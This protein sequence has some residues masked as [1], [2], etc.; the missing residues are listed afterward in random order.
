MSTGEDKIT[1]WFAE[2]SKASSDRFPIGIGDDMAQVRVGGDGSVLVTTDML[3]DGVHFDLAK[4]SVEQAGYKAMAASLSDCA[5][6]ASVPLCAVV[7]V[8]LPK[9]FGSEK[10]KE[11]HAGI[12]R[13]GDM[14]DC[15]L[16]GGD[17]TAWKEDTGRFAISVTILSRPG[18]VS[19]IRR[20]GA[21]AGDVI[22][23]TG[24]LGGSILRKH[25]EFVPRV[26]EAIR[27]TELVRIN[28]MMDI[29]DGLSMDLRRI[30]V[31]SGVG[32][33]IDAKAVPIS[34]AAFQSSGPL[35]AALND[36]EDFEL[37]FTLAAGEYDK[38]VD[39]WDMDTP[40]TKVGVITD[41]GK[42]E[43]RSPDGGV[44]QMEPKGFDHL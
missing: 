5:A 7:S 14:F 12:V 13:A 6:M 28:A 3:L 9:G 29:T 31:Q 38:L 20:S 41:S 44:E 19:P 23:V 39:A 26:R 35:G 10:L 15:T 17:I 21:K 34:F 40:T 42:I 24:E 11:L 4:V 36:G 37:L 22:C 32:A 1:G 25:I 27:L 43:L 8:G 33:M 30:C 2:Q 18:A 16:I